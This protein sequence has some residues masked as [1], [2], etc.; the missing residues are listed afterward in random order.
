MKL[1]VITGGPASGK[2]T[3]IAQLKDLGNAVLEETAREVL[4]ERRQFAINYGEKL[5]REKEIF[6]RQ[7]RK[8]E[9]IRKNHEGYFLDR[10]LIDVIAYCRHHLGYVPE[11]IKPVNLMDRYAHVFVLDR[12]PFIA[13]GTRIEKDDKEAEKIHQILIKTYKQFGYNPVSVPIFPVDKIARRA[14]FVLA[15]IKNLKGGEENGRML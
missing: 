10:S 8:E 2:T 14:N 3:L 1:Y 15:H 5:I 11:R 9:A 7:L 12:L 13:D 4:E 6:E